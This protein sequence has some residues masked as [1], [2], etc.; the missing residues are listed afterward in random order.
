[1]APVVLSAVALVAL[2]LPATAQ[3]TKT[4]AKVPTTTTYN[5]FPTA[6]PWTGPYDP[7]DPMYTGAKNVCP[8]VPWARVNPNTPN[9]DPRVGI[10]PCNYPFNQKEGKCCIP[11]NMTEG[12]EY[13]YTAFLT[14]PFYY[15]AA[16]QSV[17][18]HK[19]T[20][21]GKMLCPC[22]YSL[23]ATDNI[24]Y[25]IKSGEY[26]DKCPCG[27]TRH[28]KTGVCYDSPAAAGN[29]TQEWGECVSSSWPRAWPKDKYGYTR[30]GVQGLLCPCGYYWNPQT[31]AQEQ[32]NCCKLKG[33]SRTPFY[34]SAA[35]SGD[36]MNWPEN[37][38]GGR[39]EPH[40]SNGQRWC[41]CGYFLDID[42]YCYTMKQYKY[43]D[44]CP[45]GW[46]IDK[47]RMACFKNDRPNATQAKK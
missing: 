42:N 47:G 11:T 2:I 5:A 6:K 28:A 23:N 3:T 33:A 13:N 44:P 16:G 41:P 34:F 37:N 12:P 14:A 43:E 15:G 32:V 36:I 17:E 19:S 4:T 26:D 7:W 22:G 20:V 24:C 21:N 40:G 31:A 29:S 10:C 25:T 45:C 30:A 9:D 46:A 18:A 8:T 1:M 27:T 39:I 38:F 35:F